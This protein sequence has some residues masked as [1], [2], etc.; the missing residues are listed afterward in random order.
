MAE[1]K[2]QV[3]DQKQMYKTTRA[4]SRSKNALLQIKYCLHCKKYFVTIVTKSASISY[5]IVHLLIRIV[6]EYASNKKVTSS[7]DLDIAVKETGLAAN[8]DKNVD[9]VAH[10][11]PVIG[12]QKSKL[13][14]AQWYIFCQP[15]STVVGRAA[16]YTS[17]VSR[18]ITRI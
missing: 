15:L 4:R 17:W 13:E 18:G 14:D 8:Q 12:N 11:S 2:E 9:K 3:E 6:T 10:T 16:V 1:Q 7:T 5:L